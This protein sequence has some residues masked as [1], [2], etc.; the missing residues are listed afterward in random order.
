[1]PVKRPKIGEIWKPRVGENYTPHT[2]ALIVSKMKKDS[3]G[4][5]YYDVIS[6]NTLNT[7]YKQSRIYY[8]IRTP[9]DEHAWEYFC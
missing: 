2:C 5:E 9:D 1:M 4:D 6:L 7:T 3:D 8:Y